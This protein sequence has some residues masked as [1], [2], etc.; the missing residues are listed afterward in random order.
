MGRKYRQQRTTWSSLGGGS[1]ESFQAGETRRLGISKRKSGEMEGIRQRKGSTQAK[2]QWRGKGMD[3]NIRRLSLVRGMPSLTQKWRLETEGEGRALP[4]NERWGHV[5]LI[6]KQVWGI[7]WEDW[8]QLPLGL[9]LER[10][11]WGEI[12]CTR[13]CGA[14]WGGE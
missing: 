14:S 10:R 6:R 7:K 11:G 3:E 8:P 5:L 1:H 12:G 13:Y 9:K 4:S 2:S